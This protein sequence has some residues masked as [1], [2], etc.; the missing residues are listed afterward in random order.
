[1]LFL[2]FLVKLLGALRPFE[3]VLKLLA[4]IMI[5]WLRSY[6]EPP[7]ESFTSV[8][9]KDTS[10]IFYR[11]GISIREMSQRNPSQSNKIESQNYFEGKWLKKMN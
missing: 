3:K 10:Y 4:G 1:M 7:H 5:K 8:S 9:D 6:R 11:V 2:G